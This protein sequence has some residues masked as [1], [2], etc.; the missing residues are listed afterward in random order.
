MGVDFLDDSGRRMGAEVLDI[1]AML[2]F[3]IDGLDLP[4]AMV[5][6]DEFGMGIGL[7]IVEGGQQPTGAEPRPLVPKQPRGDDL[8]QVG[9]LAAGGRCRMEF[10]HPLVVTESTPTLDITGLLIGEPDEEMRSAQ[11]NTADGRIGKKSRDPSGPSRYAES[12]A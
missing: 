7:W 8:G 12:I 2:P 10:D 6:I 9:I 4:A 5:E 1:Q 3:S 11:G